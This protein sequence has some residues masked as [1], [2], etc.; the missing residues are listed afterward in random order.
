M[1]AHVHK[2]YQ[3]QTLQLLP[4]GRGYGAGWVVIREYQFRA[5]AENDGRLIVDM[6]HSLDVRIRNAD[7]SRVWTLREEGTGGPGR[8]YPAGL[9]L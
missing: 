5:E 9:G 2:P 7:T 3:L 6:S 1:N 8:M 4:E